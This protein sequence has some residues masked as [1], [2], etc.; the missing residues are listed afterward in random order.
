[1]ST[2]ERQQDPGEHGYGGGNQDL[3]T[4][5]E[6]REETPQERAAE[7]TAERRRLSEEQ[8]EKESENVGEHVVPTDEVELPAQE[9]THERVDP[10]L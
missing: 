1:M 5:D 9:D 4:G 3:P 7:E 8:S 2:P 10:A 6:E